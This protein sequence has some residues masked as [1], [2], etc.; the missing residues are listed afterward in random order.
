YPGRRWGFAAVGAGTR[1]PQRPHPRR[2]RPRYPRRSRNR[3]ARRRTARPGHR[4][5]SRHRPLRRLS[6]GR[7]Q[8]RRYRRW[9]AALQRAKD[10]GGAERAMTAQPGSKPPGPTLELRDLVVAYG[11]NIAATDVTATIEPGTI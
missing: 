8:R 4:R 10:R 1:R 5:A 3:P 6:R 7:G 9:H 11:N 2:R